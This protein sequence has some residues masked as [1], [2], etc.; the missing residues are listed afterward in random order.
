MAKLI[1]RVPANYHGSPGE[2]EV[3]LALRHLPDD[4]YVFHSL[5][6]LAR[7]YRGT[8]GEADI[9]IFHPAKGFFII[10]IKSGGIRCEDRVWYQTN[11]STKETCR[12]WD[13]AEQA[14]RNR[15][16]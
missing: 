11:L 2:R 6:W 16:F 1:P 9:A 10:E 3:V 7:H 8:Q 14:E 15:F 5:R 4:Y 12:I 13:P